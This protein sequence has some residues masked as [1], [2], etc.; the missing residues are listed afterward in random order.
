MH[1][2][3]FHPFL[4]FFLLFDQ[5]HT[6]DDNYFFDESCSVAEVDNSFDLM[7]LDLSNNK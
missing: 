4:L 5:G 7:L 3:N 6:E 1:K 2:S